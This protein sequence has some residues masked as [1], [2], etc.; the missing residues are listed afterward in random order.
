MSWRHT[1]V[2]ARTACQRFQMKKRLKFGR[3]SH[4]DSLTLSLVFVHRSYVFVAW[5]AESGHDLSQA[6]AIACI[7]DQDWPEQ[8]PELLPS[9]A[10]C[11]SSDDAGLVNGAVR[12]ISFLSDSFATDNIA[13]LVEALFPPLLAIIEGSHGHG[14]RTRMRSLHI[15]EK[16]LSCMHL[17]L[18]DS[19]TKV[20]VSTCVA[21]QI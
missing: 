11:L 6:M 15:V 17:R 4:L 21:G 18:G 8:W 16:M 1:G 2:I 9:L 7:G 12:C 20:R 19:S 3:V 5:V 10:G 13:A 14:P